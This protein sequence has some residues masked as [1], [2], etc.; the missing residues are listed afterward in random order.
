MSGVEMSC[1]AE[2]DTNMRLPASGARLPET[3]HPG[4]PEA[5]SRKPRLFLLQRPS[6][7]LRRNRL[8]FDRLRRN[9]AHNVVRLDIL[10]SH[11]D[12]S[13]NP[14]LADP[15]STEHGPA[16]GDSCPRSDLSRVAPHTPTS[17]QLI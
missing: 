16:I 3:L 9:S 7:L 13:D 14:M 15:D 1:S 10:R 2:F 12:R 4:T 11:A 8:H 6:Q 5:G 17:T